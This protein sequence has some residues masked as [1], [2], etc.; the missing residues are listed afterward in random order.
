[1]PFALWRQPDTT[2]DQLA[3]IWRR[4][5]DVDE[6]AVTMTGE[7]CDCFATKRDGVRHILAAVERAFPATGPIHVWTTAG[8]VRHDRRCEP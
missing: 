7:L 6:L 4:L 2:A 8:R 5:P 1:M 3:P